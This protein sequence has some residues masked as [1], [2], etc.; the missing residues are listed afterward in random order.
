MKVSFDRFVVIFVLIFSV[1][2]GYT[3]ENLEKTEEAATSKPL[4]LTEAY[5]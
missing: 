4:T 2:T 3:A 5:T 1:N